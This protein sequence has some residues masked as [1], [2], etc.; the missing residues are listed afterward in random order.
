M[1]KTEKKYEIFSKRVIAFILDILILFPILFLLS[2]ILIQVLGPP[3][4][5]F[6]TYIRIIINFSIP[7]WIYSILNDFSKSG[8]SY[9]KKIMKIKVISSKNVRLNLFQA[10]LRTAIKLIPWEMTHLTFFGLSETWG[11]F[12]IIQIVLVVIIYIL[13]FMYIFIMIK[14]RGLKGIHDYISNT[15]VILVG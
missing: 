2:I 10:I 4:T 12:S 3:V 11:S 8:S 14:T 7:F 13:I 1:T 6:Q 9:G 5:P 15:Q